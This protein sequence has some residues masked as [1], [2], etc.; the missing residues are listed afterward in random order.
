MN[1]FKSNTLIILSISAILWLTVGCSKL[2]KSNYDRLKI[3]MAYD[4]VVKMLGKADTCNSAIGFMNCK[5]GDDKKNIT[6]KF[7]GKKVIIFSSHGL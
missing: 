1:H 4:D 3:G 7:A 6:I 5:W 2:N